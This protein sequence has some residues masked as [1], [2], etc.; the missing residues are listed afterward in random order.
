MSWASEEPLSSWHG[1]TTDGDGRVTRLELGDNGLGGTLPAALGDL[2]RLEALLVVGNV[3]L[4][5]PL[6]AGLREL[7]ALAT[8]D[9]TDTELCAPGDTAFQDWT[10]TISF[11]GL[12][13]PA[14]IADGDRRG[15]LL[16][17]AR[18]A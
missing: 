3:H 17:T 13:L 7:P 10:A 15:G 9:L 1:V 8:V 5:G 6:P 16:H 18:P 12:I 2:A 11:S 4:A 14:G